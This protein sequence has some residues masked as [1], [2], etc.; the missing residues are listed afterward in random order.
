MFLNQNGFYG[1]AWLLRGQVNSHLRRCRWRRDLHTS[2]TLGN[3]CS[4]KMVIYY[5]NFEYEGKTPN[6]GAKFYHFKG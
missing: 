2:H 6:F 4:S 1:K 3:I 5:P